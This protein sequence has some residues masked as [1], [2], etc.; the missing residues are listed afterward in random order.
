MRV[1]SGSAGFLR[2]ELELEFSFELVFA[3]GLISAMGLGVK[4]ALAFAFASTFAFAAGE[5]IVPP[6]GIPS[7]PFPVGG[8]AGWTAWLFGS[9]LR[10]VSWLEFVFAGGV[11]FLVNA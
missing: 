9:A 6:D 7:S 2:F 1:G 4:A 3:V 5:V 8:G 11:E 10:P